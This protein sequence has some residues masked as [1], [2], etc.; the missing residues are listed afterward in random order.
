MA[1]EG[2]DDQPVQ[3][4]ALAATT[5]GKHILSAGLVGG[6]ITL[7]DINVIVPTGAC[8][9]STTGT[10][11]T[12][13]PL[14]IQHAA[15]PYTQTAL[16]ANATAVNQV[17]ASPVSNLAFVT[18]DGNSPGAQLPYYLPSSTGGAGTVGYVTLTGGSAS[19]RANCRSI[20]GGRLHLLCLHG[21]RQQDSLHLHTQQSL[22]SQS[23][24]GF[25]ADQS[26]PSRL[27]A[28]ISG[29]Q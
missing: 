5:D 24:D 17:V 9:S 8:P 22:R 14:T 29:W 3:S 11:R 28:G 16:T 15:T 21:G 19:Y 4:D 23:A 27:H 26:Q 10:T 20:Y 13:L 18:F 12:L 7:N 2:G 25:A 6:G 1:T